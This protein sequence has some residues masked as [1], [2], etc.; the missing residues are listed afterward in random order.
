MSVCQ[1]MVTGTCEK[2]SDREREDLFKFT[3]SET[4]VF[5]AEAARKQRN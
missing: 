1:L 5:M 3:D 4:S 2:T